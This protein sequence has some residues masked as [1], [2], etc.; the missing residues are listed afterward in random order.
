MDIQGD[1]CSVK[2]PSKLNTTELQD[3][4]LNIRN[5]IIDL[6]ANENRDL[7]TSTA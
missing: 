4:I 1:F 6:L 3:E 7:N 2:E 5:V